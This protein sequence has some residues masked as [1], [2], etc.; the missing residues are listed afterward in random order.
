MELKEAYK[1]IWIVKGYI[2]NWPEDEVL[3]TGDSYL[4]RIW[5]NEESYRYEEGFEE[6]WE[7]WKKNQ[8]E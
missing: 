1:L 6:A 7:E 2:P 3:K 8:K 5:H 4:R